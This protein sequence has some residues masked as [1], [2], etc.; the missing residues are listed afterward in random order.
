MKGLKDEEGS[1]EFSLTFPVNPVVL[2]FVLLAACWVF[3]KLCSP[4]GAEVPSFHCTKSFL[5]ES[6]I[7]QRWQGLFPFPCLTTRVAVT[8]L[9]AAS[10]VEAYRRFYH[11]TRRRLSFKLG[12]RREGEAEEVIGILL[13]HFRQWRSIQPSREE[14]ASPTFAQRQILSYQRI[15]SSTWAAL[16]KICKDPNLCSVVAR[17]YD[18]A[19]FDQLMIETIPTYLAAHGVYCTPSF[20]L[21][22]VPSGEI[23][24]QLQP[25]RCTM[26]KLSKHRTSDRN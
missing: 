15:E 26:S 25:W 8:A 1:A 16:Q 7:M 23:F 14:A 5:A 21:Y 19:K 10:I 20:F 6:S 4:P 17:P 12:D 13:E 24:S 2:A 11:S 3:A 22:A 18:V 9:P